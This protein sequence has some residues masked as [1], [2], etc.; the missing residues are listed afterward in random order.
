MIEC[1]DRQ[2]CLIAL[3]HYHILMT[4]LDFMSRRIGHSAGLHLIGDVG[5]AR[6]L[7]GHG[8]VGRGAVEEGREGG[9]VVYDSGCGRDISFGISSLRKKTASPI[10]FLRKSIKVAKTTTNSLISIVSFN[11]G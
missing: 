6:C 5:A 3:R 8:I 10:S 1:V 11:S 2:N 7:G 9:G 4:V